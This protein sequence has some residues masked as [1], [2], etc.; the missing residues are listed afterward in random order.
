MN[1]ENSMQTY[2]TQK[3]VGFTLIEL[4]VVIVI[5]GILAATALPRFADL[6]ADARIA[7]VKAARGS[8]AATSAMVHGAF[9]VRN[10]PTTVDLEGHTVAIVNGYP[11]AAT[12][13]TGA[14]ITAVDYDITA[15]ATT[16]K[17]SPRSVGATVHTAGT[18]SVV[19]TQAASAGTA[20]D[21]TT[22][23]SAC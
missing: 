17:I 21:I 8:L 20:P 6:G 11:S 7:S 13:A 19:Y 5:L 2:S 23:T 3:Q 18:C 9:L 10:A 22:T 15:T 16:V 1:S 12:V 14:G 4:I